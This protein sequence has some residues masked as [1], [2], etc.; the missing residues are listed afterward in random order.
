M[1][2][3]VTSLQKVSRARD[4]V[5]SFSSNTYYLFMG[6]H[7]ADNNSALSI[8][9]DDVN[10]TIID[11]YR[12]MIQGKVVTSD[13]V[14]PA[15]RNIP[16]QANTVYDMYDDQD[17]DLS[18]KDFYVVVNE[19]S[20]YHIYKCLDNNL[21]SPSTAQP[22]FS[23]ISGSN[24]TIYQTSDGYR[25]KYMFSVGSDVYNKFS[26]DQLIP[27]TPNT[28]VIAE[29]EHGSIDII[30][31]ET[32]G[33]RYDNY[34]LGSFKSN[35]LRINSNTRLYAISNT[36]ASTVNGFYTGCILYISSG[37][38]IGENRI[39]E[40]YISN[41]NGNFIVLDTS[42]VSPMNGSQYQIYPAISVKQGNETVSVVG[43]ALVNSL[44]SNSISQIELF[45]R[46]SGYDQQYIS[47]SVVANVAVPIV[48]K[49]SL[50][51]I[52]SPPRGHGYDA[53]EELYANAVAISVTVSNTE[54]NTILGV[55]SFQQFGLIYNPSFNK[56]EFEHDLSNSVFSIGE[57]FYNFRK[58]KIADN[59]AIN[60][61][62]SVISSNDGAFDEQLNIDEMIY[63]QSDDG[64]AQQ[65]INV[66]SISNSSTI[67]CYGLGLFSSSS[68]KVY[69]VDI[70]SK[71][72]ISQVIDPTHFV[73][74]DCT[75]S[76]S[77]NTSIV[78]YASGKLAT[79][80]TISRND[81]TKDF[82]TFIQ[83]NKYKGTVASG[84]FQPNE[85]VL[86]GN[87][88][89]SL[90][91][92]IGNSMYVSNQSGNFVTSTSIIG[93]TSGAVYNISDKY[94]P[95]LSYGSGSI[96]YLEN[97]GAVTRSNT[98]NEKFQIYFEF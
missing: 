44:A 94:E 50:R 92:M 69:K 46:G 61:T 66:Q 55:S 51:V 31:I 59:A 23:H 73:A 35:D 77:T 85:I 63:I 15:I 93:Q 17:V 74:T 5:D 20:Y 32:Q 60:T 80:N 28:S 39:I 2:S 89:A 82:S 87:T 41:E 24:N 57:T 75:P 7:I 29:A 81:I 12:N 19:E 1:A 36:T 22:T 38:G 37:P 53:A 84:T 72:R 14:A 76:F 47:A 33:K 11:V 91:A 48:Q 96:I 78:G 79:I 65:L 97:I 9:N 49:A 88:T 70:V 45:E 54:S 16:Y 3:L 26:S 62:S 90:F 6:N 42:L 13:D 67:N 83:L 4:F 40:D 43:R 25:W 98:E 8:V 18:K 71:G 86:Q 56:V 64:T 30:K 27:V 58:I 34:I 68:C 52:Y 95:E 21:G 10:D